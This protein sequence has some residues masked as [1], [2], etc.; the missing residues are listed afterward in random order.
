MFEI[1]IAHISDLHFTS[2][3][4][5]P[6]PKDKP[7]DDFSTKLTELREDLVK[8]RP[9]VLMVTGDIA[10]NAS[11]EVTQDNLVTAWTYA[12][13]F[14]EDVGRALFEK[15]ERVKERLF[16]IPG[17]H[18]AGILGNIPRERLA[19]IADSVVFQ[20]GTG[21]FGSGLL[22]PA[23]R[24]VLRDRGLAGLYKEDI[25]PLLR[26]QLREGLESVNSDSQK[27]FEVFD[28]YTASR[29]IA[30]LGL[31]VFCIDS[32]VGGNSLLNFAQGEVSQDQAVRLRAQADAW[33]KECGTDFDS[34][35]KFL[36]LHHHPLPIPYTEGLGERFEGEEFNLLRNAASVI[37]RSMDFRIDFLLHGHKH[38][39]T[40]SVITFPEHG[41]DRS[42]IVVGAGSSTVPLNGHCSYNIIRRDDEGQWWLEVRE[43]QDQRHGIEPFRPVL[44]SPGTRVATR[45]RHNALKLRGAKKDIKVGRLDVMV[46]IDSTGNSWNELY[47]KDVRPSVDG[48]RLDKY[49]VGFGNEAKRAT[50]EPRGFEDTHPENNKVEG[51]VTIDPFATAIAPRDLSFGIYGKGTYTFSREYCEW[52]KGSPKERLSWIIKKHYDEL[53]I[54]ITFPEEFVLND[55]QILVTPTL[56][57][58]QSPFACHDRLRGEEA[59]C[60]RSFNWYPELGRLS[61]FVRDPLPDQV[62]HIAWTLPDN[63][64]WTLPEEFRAKTRAAIEFLRGHLLVLDKAAQEREK[65]NEFLKQCGRDVLE[66]AAAEPL[67][68][69]LAIHDEQSRKLKVVAAMQIDQGSNWQESA[70]RPVCEL[71]ET[72]RGKA[73]LQREILFFQPGI[74]DSRKNPN[75]DESERT[76]KNQISIPLTYPPEL[77][78]YPRIGVLTISS[79]YEGSSLFERLGESIARPDEQTYASQIHQRVNAKIEQLVRAMGGPRLPSYPPY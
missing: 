23:L 25:E 75:R 5:W 53:Y 41:L 55:R 45:E 4:E 33:T 32:N 36:L 16:V 18:D 46:R 65:V 10:D 71:G 6:K 58:E 19:E 34:S 37:R 11:W 79:E 21:L 73:F 2:R 44:P 22:K 38:S 56:R 20:V 1:T 54:E 49:P 43:R 27:F 48:V 64:Y 51:F 47:A 61:L 14:L 62:Y 52:Y 68:L 28:P 76:T 69:D 31:F 17:N 74:E 50:F 60:G 7:F 39:R 9:D 77:P 42:L 70:L 67:R 66:L 30:D 8:Q 40:S 57:P 3:M 26:R 13:K 24:K 63:E 15:T 72:L 59:V 12:R 35:Y 78:F 29:R